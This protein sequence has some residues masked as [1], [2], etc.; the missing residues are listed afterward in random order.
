MPAI[1]PP[2]V[3]PDVEGMRVA[4]S[5]ADADEREAVGDALRWLGAE[6]VRD[7]AQV[8][9]GAPSGSEKMRWLRVD[10]PGGLLRPLAPHAIRHALL[11]ILVGFGI[12]G[13]GFGVILAIVGRAAAPEHRSMALGIATAAGSAGQIV[14]PPIAAALLEV[15][16][17]QSVFLIFAVAVLATLAL[18]PFL[19]GAEA[20][21]TKAELE[22]SLGTVLLRA[23]KDPS[24]TLLFLGFFSCGYQLGFITAHFPAFVAE[25]CGPIAPGGLLDS[26]GISSTSAL[27]GWALAVIGIMNIGGTVLAGKLGGR[28]PKKYLLSAIYTGRT[29]FAAAFILVPMTP[30]TVLIF[31]VG[32]GALWLATV[33][34]TSGLVA[35]IWGLRHMGTLYGFIFFSHQLGSF[36]GIWLGGRLHDL[37]GSYDAVWWIGVAVG[38]FSALV[39]LPIRES[40]TAAPAPA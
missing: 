32:M 27:G 30:A 21:A 16:S 37:Y 19:R 39:H 13:T 29:I 31:S 34:L 3:D 33:P 7:G 28:Y 1:A 4:L 25:V 9:I 26:I 6:V 17:W 15:M 8:G 22:E 12:A 35:H 20:P 5:L 14:V 2:A 11:E 38:A 23:A 36:L 40:R 10:V 18:L 24:Y